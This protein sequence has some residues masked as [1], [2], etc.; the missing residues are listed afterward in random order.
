MKDKTQNTL[1]WIVLPFASI[2][3][4]ILAFAFCQMC[5]IN[6]S[7]N[8][9]EEGFG[10]W[11]W[12][13]LSF[14]SSGCAFVYISTL[15]APKRKDIVAVVAT[16]FVV[17]LC[18]LWGIIGFIA[19]IDRL[20]SLYLFAIIS[21]ISG[22][23]GAIAVGTER[24]K[25][26]ANISNTTSSTTTNMEIILRKPKI[27]K[28]NEVLDF[29]DNLNIDE[30]Q[31]MHDDLIE[32]YGCCK[33][34]DIVIGKLVNELSHHSC[35]GW[36]EEID[37]HLRVLELLQPINGE[38]KYT[39]FTTPEALA[40]IA[41]IDYIKISDAITEFTRMAYNADVRSR[42][43]LTIMT[44]PNMKMQANKL[45][46]QKRLYEE[47]IDTLVKI[48]NHIGK[49]LHDEHKF[50]DTG[51][52]LSSKMYSIDGIACGFIANGKLYLN[53][54]MG[55]HKAP[56]HLY[57]YVWMKHCKKVEPEL[58]NKIYDYAVT[59]DYFQHIRFSPRF[60]DLDIEEAAIKAVCYLTSF[61]AKDI[62]LDE[63]KKQELLMKLETAE[64]E[65]ELLIRYPLAAFIKKEDVSSTLKTL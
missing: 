29:A 25:K 62:F 49:T 9:I 50:K 51:N 22:T 60:S 32:E 4:A 34:I 8:E 27:M 61:D 14:F 33:A 53:S 13:F 65:N 24:Y 36:S 43:I 48:Q 44:D 41:T 5:Q 56:I 46:L 47:T 17:F 28:G 12:V 35:T 6:E 57:T 39:H 23:V 42:A 64:C 55:N 18:T 11:F 21:A 31:Q 19:T 63:T 2:I 58:F 59:T 30:I 15:V 3:A 1:R 40:E 45:H 10:Y 38:S 7:H 26:Y 52:I 54:D 37:K 20:S 16:A